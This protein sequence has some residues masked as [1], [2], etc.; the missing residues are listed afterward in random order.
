MGTSGGGAFAFSGE[1]AA[2]AMKSRSRFIT[3]SLASSSSR[4]GIEARAHAGF[5]EHLTRVRARL[6]HQLVV[7]LGE[8]VE[9]LGRG[10]G[11]SEMA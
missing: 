1:Q 3:S 10:N 8:L 2:D 6:E 4:L 7:G 9:H 5:I 11:I